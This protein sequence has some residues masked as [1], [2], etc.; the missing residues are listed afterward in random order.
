MTAANVG[1]PA[2]K[3]TLGLHKMALAAYFVYKKFAYYL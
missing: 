2:K 1:L 3:P